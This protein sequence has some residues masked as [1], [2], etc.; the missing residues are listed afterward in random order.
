MAQHV[1]HLHT[2]ARGHGVGIA[3][4]LLLCSA[5]HFASG[6]PEMDFC[7]RVPLNILDIIRVAA[8]A[9]PFLTVP[10]RA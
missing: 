8:T 4:R 1:R 10:G 5:S 6:P 7:F 3:L 9:D 2:A